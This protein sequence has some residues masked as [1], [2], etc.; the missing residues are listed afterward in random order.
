MMAVLLAGFVCV[1]GGLMMADAA[2]DWSARRERMIAE[3]RQMVFDTRLDTGREVIAAPVIAALRRVERHRYVPQR[4]AAQAYE[5]RPLSIG[6]GQTISQP[7]MV[8][9]MTDLLNV[10][11]GDRVLEV[12]TGSGYQAAV[13]GEL[14]SAV[15]SIEIVESLGREA[16]R[17]LAAAGYRNVHTRIGD[18]YAGWPDEAP[19]DGIMVTAAAPAVPQ[20]LI[21]QLKS[22]GRLVIPLGEPQGAQSLFVLEKNQRGAVTRRKVLDV[23][24][25]P[26]TRR[27]G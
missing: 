14:V 9:L 6:E 16:A 8:A 13:L 5:N 19:F 23:R 25:V 4:F 20:P 27:P 15:F 18:G 26:F 11:P 3:I 17:T 1:P 21:D 7:Y 2:D 12:G 24:F 22:G 10:R